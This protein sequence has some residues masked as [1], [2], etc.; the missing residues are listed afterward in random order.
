MEPLGWKL[1]A[2]NPVFR[3]AGNSP[4]TELAIADEP[5]TPAHARIAT[6]ASALSTPCGSEKQMIACVY[7]R[8]HVVGSGSGNAGAALESE[9]SATEHSAAS[10][11]SEAV[12]SPASCGSDAAT[13][14]LEGGDPTPRPTS[15]TLGLEEPSFV[16]AQ[17]VAAEAGDLP[18]Q[19]PQPEALRPAQPLP[20]VDREAALVPSVDPAEAEEAALPPPLATSAEK[21]RSSLLSYYAQTGE[22]RTIEAGA[23]PRCVTLSPTDA[24]APS[25]S[26]KVSRVLTRLPGALPLVVRGLV[27]LGLLAGLAWV[28]LTGPPHLLSRA[29]SPAPGLKL[30]VGPREL[31]PLWRRMQSAAAAQATTAPIPAPATLAGVNPW[32]LPR[33]VLDG[34]AA[35]L[36]RIVR[37]GAP[38]LAPP[39]DPGAPVPASARVQAAEEAGPSLAHRARQLSAWVQ[40]GPAGRVLGATRGTMGASLPSLALLGPVLAFGGPALLLVGVLAACLLAGQSSTGSASTTGLASGAATEAPD[41]PTH[42]PAVGGRLARRGGVAGARDALSFQGGRGTTTSPCT[43]PVWKHGGGALA[44]SSAGHAQRVTRRS[45]TQPPRRRRTATAPRPQTASP[46][47]S[48]TARQS[49]KRGADSAL[50]GPTASTSTPGVHTRRM[51]RTAL[52]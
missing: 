13:D 17:R 22:T 1:R 8:S 3:E 28:P 50:T 47:A 52:A 7:P 39:H 40:A 16:T 14:L 41:F 32:T 49:A 29:A 36:S 21:A 33:A 42:T 19:K 44:A 4:H 46:V 23:E 25:S 48:Y 10:M 35:A 6:A 51:A 15:R 20:G 12:D 34:P 9:A 43:A 45:P 37:A 38:G 26:G 18:G 2:N 5:G 27:L 30:V 31:L 24:P 11:G